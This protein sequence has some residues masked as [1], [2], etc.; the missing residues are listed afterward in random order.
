M[1]V[2]YFALAILSIRPSTLGKG[3]GSTF[4]NLSTSLKSTHI[5]TSWE[6][7]LLTMTIGS[8]HSLTDSSMIPCVMHVQREAK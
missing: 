2:M 7:F 1:V 8:A 4:A 5:W 6:S 3:Y